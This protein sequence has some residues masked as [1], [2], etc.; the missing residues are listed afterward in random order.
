MDNLN[1]VQGETDSSRNRF[2]QTLKRFGYHRF[3]T[4]GCKGLA[5]IIA[6]KY[7]TELRTFEKK[8]DLNRFKSFKGLVQLGQ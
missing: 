2:I 4:L 5:Q 8:T 7:V 3:T 1:L 6:K